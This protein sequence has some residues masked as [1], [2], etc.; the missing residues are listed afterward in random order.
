MVQ[1]VHAEAFQLM[2]YLAVDGQSMWIWNSRDG[3]TP[4]M[5]L[6][7][8][9]EYHHAMSGDGLARTAFLPDKATHV[10]V[11]YTPETWKTMSRSRY[12][13]IVGRGGDTAAHLLSA[14]PMPEDWMKAVP[15]E[16][17]QPCLLTREQFLESQVSWMGGPDPEFP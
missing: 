5:L 8:D 14:Y 13:R 11:D 6:L 1:I 16:Y 17:G 15:F 2:C 3:V 9:K 10:W 4:F 12:D 7:E